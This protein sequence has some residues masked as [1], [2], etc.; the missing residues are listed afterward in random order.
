[1]KALQDWRSYFASIS[2]SIQIFT[3]HKNLRNFTTIK[4]LNQWQICWAEQLADFEFQIYYKKN[5]ENS[6]ADTLSRQS[7]HK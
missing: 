7:D 6:D 1:M 5:N 4:Q 3:D 2:K